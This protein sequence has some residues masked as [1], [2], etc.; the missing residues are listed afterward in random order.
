MKRAPKTVAGPTLII[1]Q[2]PNSSQDPIPLAIDA[3]YAYFAAGGSGNVSIYQVA[4]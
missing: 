3:N 4:K 2:V 1:A